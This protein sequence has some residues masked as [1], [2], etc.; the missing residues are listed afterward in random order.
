[1]SEVAAIA[2]EDAIMDSESDIV[3][4]PPRS[5]TLLSATR[6]AEAETSAVWTPAPGSAAPRTSIIPPM[7]ATKPTIR[8]HD[9]F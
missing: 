7:R 2:A 5:R 4:P 8:S 1:M 6:R 9:L 3:P